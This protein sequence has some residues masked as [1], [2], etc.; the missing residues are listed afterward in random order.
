MKIR[1]NTNQLKKKIINL[2]GIK[3]GGEDPI[4]ISGPCA[5]ESEEQIYKSAKFMK[6]IGVDILRGGCF[7]PRT[8]PYS[9]QGLENDGIKYL[10]GAAKKYDLTI[11]SEVITLEQLEFSYDYLDIIQVGSRNMYNYPLL[12]ELGSIE[13]PV[14][15]KRAFSATYEEWLLAAQYI[16]NSG[17]SDI[18]LCE[19]GIRTFEIGTRNTLDI[20]AIPYI[21]SKSNLPI[22]IDPSHASGLSEFIKPLSLS[23]IAAGADGLMIETHPDPKSALCDGRQSLNFDEFKDL[24]YSVNKLSNCLKEIY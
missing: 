10:S 21:Q 6:E 18:I 12:K 14:L 22:I 4:I 24:F 1:E 16:I 2:N 17:N 15:L 7:K 13:K 8:S 23:A 9:F 11:V 3:I 19:R 20:S 5:V